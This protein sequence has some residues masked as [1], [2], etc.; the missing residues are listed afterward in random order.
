MLIGLNNDYQGNIF[1]NGVNSFV[2]G[3]RKE[4]FSVDKY[5]NFSLKNFSK[6][7]EN[8]FSNNTSLLL[9]DR[10]NQDSS[11]LNPIARKSNL[12]IV[13]SL[14][15]YEKRMSTL[16]RNNLSKK[17]EIIN[18]DNNLLILRQKGGDLIPVNVGQIVNEPNAINLPLY[19]STEVKVAT[20]NKEVEDLLKQNAILEPAKVVVIYDLDGNV[21]SSDFVIDGSY[22][23]GNYDNKDTVIDN[24]LNTF[25]LNQNTELVYY[26]KNDGTSEK[27]KNSINQIYTLNLNG[28]LYYYP[29]FNDA[30]NQLKNYI[31]TNSTKIIN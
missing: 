19:N 13:L 20:T 23:D 12:G 1:I 18:D 7:Y 14:Y 6:K 15:E 27:I 22:G 16:E 21:V 2:K 29:S 5:N 25:I 11:S 4:I 10:L 30:R 24:A 31:E 26:Q 28:N 17:S 8:L 9:K 3:S